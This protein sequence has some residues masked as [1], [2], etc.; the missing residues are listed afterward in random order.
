VVLYILEDFDERYRLRDE[1]RDGGRRPV[2]ERRLL[3]RP[4]ADG[5]WLWQLSSFGAVDG[6]DG[7]ADINIM[8]ANGAAGRP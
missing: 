4:A 5:W 1:L 7:R 8:S 3:R 6:I 2:W